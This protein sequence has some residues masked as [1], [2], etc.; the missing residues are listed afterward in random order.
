MLLD[1][2]SRQ[3]KRV[4]SVITS[5]PVH[6]DQVLSSRAPRTSTAL[7]LNQSAQSQKNKQTQFP[8]FD[9]HCTR[10][11]SSNSLQRASRMKINPL[12]KLKPHKTTP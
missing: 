11:A 6:D 8:I 5:T 4:K 7:K 3:N 12:S 10:S 1:D 2:H 9:L